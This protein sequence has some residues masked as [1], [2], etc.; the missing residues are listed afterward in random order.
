VE[1][2]SL[3]PLLENPAA[4]W[5]DRLLVT[6]QGRWEAGEATDAKY[7]ATAIRD[8]RFKLVNGTELYDLAADPGEQ[9]DVGARH[10]RV[11]G[12]LRAAFD[13]WWDEV[14]PATVANE[15]TLGPYLNP[16]AERYWRQ[17]GDDRT[18]AQV[19]R[20]NPAWK[21]VRPRPAF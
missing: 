4:P 8:A 14:L 9:H 12:R 20:M 18:Q 1:G 10:P 19:D 16:F 17:F 13:A 6:H 21:F 7:R 5:P 15:Q 2:R 11:A 3:L